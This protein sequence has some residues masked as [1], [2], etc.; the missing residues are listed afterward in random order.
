[1]TG[2]A[3]SRSRR[4]I[5]H[6]LLVD[7]HPARIQLDAEGP[8][9][10]AGDGRAEQRPADAG[11]RVEHELAGPAEELDEAGHQPRRLVGA[12]RLAGGVP[13]LGRIGRRQHRLREVEP[14]LAGQLVE[15]VVGVRRRAAVGHAA[16]RS[17]ARR[18]SRPDGRNHGSSAAERGLE[19]P[20]C[21][22]GTRARGSWGARTRSR[23][24]PPSSSATSGRAPGDAHRAARP[25]S[26]S[27]GS[28]TR[29]SA[30]SAGSR[31]RCASC[32]AAPSG[33]HGRAVRSGRAGR[34]AG[35]RRAL[36][37]RPRR[38]PRSRRRR[39]R[40]PHARI[41]A[42]LDAHR[43]AAVDPARGCART[44]PGAPAR[45]RPRRA[46]PARRAA[47]RPARHRGP[48][49]RRCGDPRA[50]HVP[51]PDRLG[52]AAGD[53]RLGPAR[54]RPARRP[55]DQRAGVHRRGA[56]TAW[57]DSRC[58]SSIATNSPRSSRA[59]RASGRRP[60]SCSWSPSAPAAVPLVAEELLAARREL[61][62]A[63][64]TGSFEDL[65]LGRLVV[66]SPECRRVLRLLAPAGRPLDPEHLAA[67]A[68]DFEV[69]D[70]PTGPRAPSSG[71]AAGRRDPRRGP[72]RGPGRG[73]RARFPGRARRRG[74]V[75]AT[76]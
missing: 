47:A 29:R 15:R 53:H 27:A 28:S 25:A 55:M 34:R 63:S 35:A 18:T 33:R 32:A 64:L 71:P 65:V 10:S 76:S 72:G 73:D 17:R 61:P 67:V 20:P 69:G 38:R 19:W 49:S 1:M 66:R 26:G 21:P 43:P 60:A 24:S 6:D 11:E 58:R 42:R 40:T 62:T 31:S 41:A 54:H 45:G 12:V 13:E 56:P 16:Q 44:P 3:P 50:R 4:Q 14:L 48:A 9:R 46:R 57:S 59:S 8:P 37:R 68:D 2:P 36:R 22:A 39:Y 30:A 5:E 51:R 74:R 7:G 75:P 23:G 70:R 52:P